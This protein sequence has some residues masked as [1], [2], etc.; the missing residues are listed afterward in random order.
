VL[1][2]KETATGDGSTL[3]SDYT[4]VFLTEKKQTEEK[5]VPSF[6]FFMT[7]GSFCIAFILRN[8]SKKNNK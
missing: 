4:W 8:K 3:G 1:I 7:L 2:K 5:T 6:I